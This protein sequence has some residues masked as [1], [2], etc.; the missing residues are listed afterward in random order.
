MRSVETT[1][2]FFADDR[3]SSTAAGLYRRFLAGHAAADQWLEC[4]HATQDLSVS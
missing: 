2:M 4:V 1:E 3:L